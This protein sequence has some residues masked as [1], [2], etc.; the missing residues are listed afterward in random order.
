MFN[1]NANANA[2]AMLSSLLFGAPSH[3][4]RDYLGY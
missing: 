3:G 1:V 4:T 2:N